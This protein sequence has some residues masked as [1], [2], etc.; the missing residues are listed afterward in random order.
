M[1][2][3]IYLLIFFFSFQACSDKKN[4]AS[5]SSSSIYP[6]SE[7]KNNSKPQNELQTGKKKSE[8]FGS[9]GISTNPN[10]KVKAGYIEFFLNAGA[11]ENGNGKSQILVK[12]NQ[13][14]GSLS[15]SNAV[16][17]IKIAGRIEILKNGN[18]KLIPET[19]LDFNNIYNIS[20][21][22]EHT[23]LEYSEKI[24]I[25][26]ANYCKPSSYF[27]T[28]PIQK[29]SGGIENTVGLEIKENIFKDPKLGQV[30]IVG[31]DHISSNSFYFKINNQTAG[32]K[33]KIVAAYGVYNIP[34]HECELY[35]QRDVNS[36]FPTWVDS[37][38]GN[39]TTTVT[40]EDT[41]IRDPATGEFYSFAKTFILVKVFNSANIDITGTD[42]GVLSLEQ[43]D[44]LYG[45]PISL[46]SD[47]ESSL[48]AYLNRGNNNSYSMVLGGLIVGIFGFFLSRRLLKRKDDNS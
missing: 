24:F 19:E 37:N 31:W 14:I 9:I 42:T 21:I 33:Y 26:V 29:I 16:T 25:S 4:K 5:H 35:L 15:L 1:K 3:I 39:K 2:Y 6:S 23:N 46:N 13:L 22:E 17:N 20:F 10:I 27:F 38:Y 44:S 40:Q 7:S 32:A 48:L 8:M 36:P 43:T 47:E 18:L 41:T 28:V 30:A 45:L 12:D 34:E 11:L